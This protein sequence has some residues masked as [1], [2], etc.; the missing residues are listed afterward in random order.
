MNRG[1]LPSVTTTNDKLFS[2]R[3]KKLKLRRTQERSVLAMTRSAIQ[4][5]YDFIILFDVKDGNRTEPDAG[6]YESM[7]KQG[8]DL[9]PMYV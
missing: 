9:L 4:N 3:K 6:I 7:R 2:P 8:M 5:R 1:T